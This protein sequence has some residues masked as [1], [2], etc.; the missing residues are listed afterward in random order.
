MSKGKRSPT[1]KQ[2]RSL[3][4]FCVRHGSHGHQH[5]V[6]VQLA[7]EGRLDFQAAYRMVGALKSFKE[8]PTPEGKLLVQELFGTYWPE[9]RVVKNPFP[10]GPVPQPKGK[11]A[12]PPADGGA[13]P[14]APEPQK[15]EPAE[16]GEDKIRELLE[17]EEAAL[18]TPK[19]ADPGQARR[20]YDVSP[21]YVIPQE[22]HE[23]FELARVGL[24]VLLTGP[25][26]LGKSRLGAELA[27]ALG[28]EG[29]FRI[30][31]GGSMRYPQ[32]FG[33]DRLVVNDQGV[34]VSVWEPSPLL[35]AIQRPVVVVIDEVF[36]AE[37][38]IT[39]GLNS[40]LEPSTRAII[41]PIGEIRMHPQCRIVGTANTNGRSLHNMYTGV[42]VQ[43]FSLVNRFVE[44][45]MTYSEEVE[46]KIL[47]ELENPKLEKYLYDMLKSLRTKIEANN[48]P[49]DASTR[50]LIACVKIVRETKLSVA[51]SFEL[52][53][54][55]G[56]SRAERAKLDV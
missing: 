43:D 38:D 46:K 41:T 55:S 44:V 34:Q 17:A 48:I 4:A 40:L 33:S 30:S 1:P 47:S 12:D 24:N 20:H 50:Q 14:D 13:R 31:F 9:F 19:A 29:C 5:D 28:L 8:N 18:E 42:A 52:A 27:R 54:L 23:V 35:R 15:S 49:Y 37:G 39:N 26:G 51:R 16:G 2:L 22:F 45:K 25:A 32:V 3:W 56:L 7:R 21:D 6:W 53:F 36:S 11:P 10:N